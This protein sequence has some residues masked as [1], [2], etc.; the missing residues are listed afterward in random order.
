M[1]DCAS[2]TGSKYSKT[3]IAEAEHQKYELKKRDG[4]WARQKR[5]QIQRSMILRL[6]PLGGMLGLEREHGGHE[7]HVQSAAA[8]I[9]AKDL[10]RHDFIQWPG[11]GLSDN[12]RSIRNFVQDSATGAIAYSLDC[13]TERSYPPN[14]P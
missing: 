9:W 8:E 10:R 14:V 4:H 13:S 12:P 6:H 11:S 5:Q 3:A 7:G 1:A 2:S